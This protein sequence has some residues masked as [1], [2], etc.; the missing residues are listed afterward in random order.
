MTEVRGFRLRYRKMNWF[1]NLEIRTKILS[2]VILMA[3]FIGSV[4][5]VGYY[6]NVKANNQMD[7]M[8]SNNLMTVKY[9]NDS[10]AQIRA[11]ESA[12]FHFLLATEKE[13]QEEEQNETRTRADNFD[14]DFS[15][16]MKIPTSESYELERQK[17]IQAELI[18]YRA[19][20]KKTLAIADG[21]DHTGAFDYYLKNADDHLESVNTAL[22]ELAT[23]NAKQADDTY[24]Q[25]DVDT[26]L[27]GKLI[28]FIS[29]VAILL[30]L[31]LGF[32]IS[33]IISNS[34]K[35]VLA[36][37]ERVAYGRFID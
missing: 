33:T 35:K 34:I 9:L 14:I 4:G 24:S 6:Y 17:I 12:T 23:Y 11:G 10:R 2:I 22:E 7:D 37:V 5:F 18:L 28:N 36:S 20:L 3:L 8:Y 29:I 25:N 21:G 31:I 30:C 27:A 26:V 1:R 15:A 32:L 16:Y 19:G 13:S